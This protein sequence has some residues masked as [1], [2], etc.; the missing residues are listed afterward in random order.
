MP[1]LALVLWVTV[2][3][4]VLAVVALFVLV[5]SMRRQLRTCA[6]AVPVKR[7][8]DAQTVV[9]RRHQLVHERQAKELRKISLR[10]PRPRFDERDTSP[11]LPPFELERQRGWS[12]DDDDTR[13]SAEGETFLPVSFE[14]DLW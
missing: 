5:F 10:I 8:L 13:D 3:C 14:H 9:L 4:L 12:D 11:S 6:R 1:T 7:A 2:A